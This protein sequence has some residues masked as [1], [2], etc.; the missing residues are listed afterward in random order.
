MHKNELDLQIA[1]TLGV[2][3]NQVRKITQTFID[4]IRNAL[5]NEGH[6]RIPR[7]GVMNVLEW[8][9]EAIINNERMRVHKSRV[10]FRRAALLEQQLREKHHG[11]IRS[12]RE[13]TSA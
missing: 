13:H 4:L 9:G 6:V 10:T 7:L 11:K 2:S 1:T 3:Q 5:V 12:R 8:D